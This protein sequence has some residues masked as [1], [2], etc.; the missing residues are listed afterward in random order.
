MHKSNV[1]RSSVACCMCALGRA[2][3]RLAGRWQAIICV[4]YA[5]NKT[6]QREGKTILFNLMASHG[7]EML[8]CSIVGCMPWQS[9]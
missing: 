1:Y 5:K 3:P 2:L 4:L 7:A 9:H 8:A 6:A